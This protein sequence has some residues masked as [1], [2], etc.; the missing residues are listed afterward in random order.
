MEAWVEHLITQ[1]LEWALFAVALVTFLE[2]L[3]F[4]GLLLPGTV[5]MASLGALVGSGQIGLYPAWAAGLAS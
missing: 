2:S 4:V 5:M 1:S 3:A